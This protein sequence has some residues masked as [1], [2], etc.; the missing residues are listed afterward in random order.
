MAGR[1]DYHLNL[2]HR[3]DI[4]AV[5]WAA[6]GAPPM[7][8]NEIFSVADDGAALKEISAWLAARLGRPAPRFTGAGD[9]GRDGRNF[10]GT[11][12]RFGGGADGRDRLK[13][14]LLRD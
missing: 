5:V 6:F 4:V 3:D 1:G 2:I 14:C 12:S 8:A 11:W 9:D 7:V 13:V 10:L